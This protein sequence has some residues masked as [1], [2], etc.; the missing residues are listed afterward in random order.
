MY[1]QGNTRAYRK[2]GRNLQ[3]SRDDSRRI[4]SHPCR[5]F[6]IFRAN[7]VFGEKRTLRRRVCLSYPSDEASRNAASRGCTCSF[8]GR[9]MRDVV[10]VSFC[11]SRLVSQALTAAGFSRC[12]ERYLPRGGEPSPRLTCYGARESQPRINSRASE[13]SE[14]SQQYHD[15]IPIASRLTCFQKFLSRK[16]LLAKFSP[17]TAKL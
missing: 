2:F 6:L 10:N 5:S 13:A 17:R 14:V 15:A 8:P 1:E 3:S 7:F 11:R 12:A 9:C 4:L 16:T